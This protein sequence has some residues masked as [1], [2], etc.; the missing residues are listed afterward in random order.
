MVRNLDFNRILWFST[1]ILAL[2][3][4][5]IGVVNPDVYSEVVSD[6][7]MPGVFGQDLLTVI[8]SITILLLLIRQRN[9][10]STRQIIILGILGYLFYAFGK[11]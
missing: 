2:I 1:A 5:L 9:G 6:D 4:A 8:A 3:A 7:I 10:D 11:I